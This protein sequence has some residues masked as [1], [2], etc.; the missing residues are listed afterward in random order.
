MARF[1]DFAGA[2][3]RAL[4]RLF[5]AATTACL[6]V[7]AQAEARD[8]EDYPAEDGSD[9]PAETETTEAGD[10][11]SYA[12]ESESVSSEGTKSSR[13]EEPGKSYL[14]VGAA[15]RY[16]RMPAWTL[17]W[18]LESAPAVGAAGSFFGEIAYRKDGFQILGTL[19]YMKWN[20]NGPFQMSGDP[21]VD[22]EWLET[23]WNLLLAT[24]AFTWSTEFT[25]WF[26]LEYGVEAG[27]AFIFGDMTRSEAFRGQ[28]GEYGKCAGPGVPDAAFCDFPLPENGVQNPATNTAGFDGAHYNVK[29]ERGIFNGGVPHVL[30]VLGPRLSLRFKPVQKIALRVDVPLPVFPLGFMGG[31]S[32]QYGF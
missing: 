27:L 31:I 17:E 4:R 14:Y 3:P 11:G 8:W 26:S 23:R 21:D 30:P 28:N 1:Y 25:D 29:A 16:T 19:G 2:R 18:F 7:T 24:A 15:W 10:D 5:L 32:A 12:G 9:S 6:V 20:F 22:T 13:A